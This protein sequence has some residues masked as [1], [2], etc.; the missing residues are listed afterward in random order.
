MRKYITLRGVAKSVVMFS[1][2]GSLWY[3]EIAVMRQLVEWVNEP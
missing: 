1:V 2:L 3:A